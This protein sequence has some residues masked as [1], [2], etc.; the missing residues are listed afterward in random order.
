MS[1]LTRSEAI[2]H[3]I[4]GFDKDRQTVFPVFQHIYSYVL[5]AIP[6]RLFAVEWYLNYV[7]N[8]LMQEYRDS[9]SHL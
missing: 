5:Y 4:L 9:C 1:A 3:I 6:F 2:N 8:T 7:E